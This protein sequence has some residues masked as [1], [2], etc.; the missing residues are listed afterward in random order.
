MPKGRGRKGGVNPHKEK[1]ATLDNYTRVAIESLE[2]TPN[3]TSSA[4][5]TSSSTEMPAL[6]Q[7]LNRYHN[8]PTYQTPHYQNTKQWNQW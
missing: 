6:P 4:P 3:S 2:D 5:T 8:S 1:K 7:L